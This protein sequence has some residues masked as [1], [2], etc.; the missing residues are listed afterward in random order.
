MAT[1][2]TEPGEMFFCLTRQSI[3]MSL[4]AWCMHVQMRIGLSLYASY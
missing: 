3:M 2:I 4:M 1:H